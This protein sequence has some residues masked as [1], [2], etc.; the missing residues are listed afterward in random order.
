MKTSV[1]I[2]PARTDY[3]DA[4]QAVREAIGLLG[5]MGRFVRKGSRVVIKPNMSFPNPPE[6]GTTT[7]P[8][9]V[10]AWRKSRESS[11]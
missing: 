2:V 3:S 8:E 4:E 6:W 7:H 5:G 1:A 9:V 11:H 10:V